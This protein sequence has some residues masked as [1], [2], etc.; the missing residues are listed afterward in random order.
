MFDV[1]VVGARCAGSPLAMLLAPRGYRVLLVDKARFPSDTVSTHLI[2]Q[3]ALARAKRWGLLDRIVGLG[4]PPIRTVR[5]DIGEFEF[6]G[7]PPP[8]EGI[9][10]AVAPRRTVL[11][12]LL[13]D[14]AVE[15]GAEL[16]EDFYISEILAE[17]GRVTGI[18]GRV[19]NG[20]VVAEK[21]R[22][23]IGADGRHSLVAHAVR[24]PKYNV[25]RS[26]ACAYY[27]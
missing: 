4:A 15:A 6:A 7:C 8:L 26:T 25:R 3:A 24:A 12:K 1:I 16:R 20:T 13:V 11:D 10:Y 21:A 9:D 14:A 23:V 5:F 17:A 2:W 27:A 22:L 18:R 19:S